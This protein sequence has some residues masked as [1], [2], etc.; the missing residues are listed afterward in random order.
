MTG[1]VERVVGSSSR[2]RLGV[3]GSPVVW[4]VC[5]GLGLSVVCP[6]GP[7]GPVVLLVWV[8]LLLVEGALSAVIV[9]CEPSVWVGVFALLVGV[10]LLVVPV[11]FAP[12]VGLVF[13]A[14][15]PGL[16]VGAA[17]PLLVPLGWVLLLGGLVVP[18]P[19]LPLVDPVSP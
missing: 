4:P 14:V 15:W 19:L 1:S 11:V 9:V 10:A 13:P 5:V 2:A 6:G 3:L 17:D 7:S 16:V 18:A 8:V 12:L